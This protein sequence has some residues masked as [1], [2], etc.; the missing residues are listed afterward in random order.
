MYFQWFIGL[1]ALWTLSAT[2]VLAQPLASFLGYR[3]QTQPGWRQLSQDEIERFYPKATKI[4][5]YGFT[6][7]KEQCFFTTG[8][9]NLKNLPANALQEMQLDPR[10]YAQALADQM[11]EQLRRNSAEQVSGRHYWQG[12]HWWTEVEF[13]L[14][15]MSPQRSNKQF[16]NIRTRRYTWQRMTLEGSTLVITAG[17]IPTSLDPKDP[18]GCRRGL[19]GFFNSFTWPN[20]QAS[21]NR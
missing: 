8:Y 11:V 5:E 21:R 4:I 16:Y 13:I 10:A 17:V 19:E 7:A 15:Q 1:F 6:S 20:V 18:N 3:F 9:K 14:E 2:P 12:N